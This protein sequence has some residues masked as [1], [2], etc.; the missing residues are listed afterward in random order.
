MQPSLGDIL[1][2]FKQILSPEDD[3]TGKKKTRAHFATAMFPQTSKIEL[4]LQG[5]PEMVKL[6]FNSGVSEV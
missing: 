1:P 5:S 2:L 6:D 4:F 3:V